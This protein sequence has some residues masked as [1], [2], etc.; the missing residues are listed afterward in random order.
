MAHAPIPIVTAH[1]LREQL[2]EVAAGAVRPIRGSY[3]STALFA[4]NYK[5]LP[6]ARI[7][8]RDLW[9]DAAFDFSVY[10][11]KF[12]IGLYLGRRERAPRMER[13]DR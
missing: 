12:L 4:M 13:P 1:G 2:R 9:I 11:R 7:E 5:F 3:G 10:D 6:D 8:W